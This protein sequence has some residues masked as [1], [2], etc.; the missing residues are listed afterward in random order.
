MLLS[1]LRF[2]CVSLTTRCRLASVF[3]LVC[4]SVDEAVQLVVPYALTVEDFL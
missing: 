4:V 2:I 1:V 3:R